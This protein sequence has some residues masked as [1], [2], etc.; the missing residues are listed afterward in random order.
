[1]SKIKQY[2]K[3]LQCHRRNRI[4]DFLCLDCYVD[5]SIANHIFGADSVKLWKEK[6]I[7]KVD[8]TPKIKPKT[9]R[10]VELDNDTSNLTEEEFMDKS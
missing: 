7:M 4:N 6:N 8:L 2:E 5:F 9:Q 10:K 1:M 3:C